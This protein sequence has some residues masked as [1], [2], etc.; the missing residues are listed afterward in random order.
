MSGEVE[1]S[2]SKIPLE[3]LWKV[4]EEVF[5]TEGL[6]AT[7]YDGDDW[8]RDSRKLRFTDTESFKSCE[9]QRRILR[10][11]CKSWKYLSDTVGRRFVPLELYDSNGKYSITDIDSIANTWRLYVGTSTKLPPGLSGATVQWRILR[12]AQDVAEDVAQISHPHLRRVEIYFSDEGDTSYAPDNL[13]G[14][15]KSFVN[16]TW[17]RYLTNTNARHGHCV[18]DDEG[19]T[20]TLPHLQVLYYYGYGALHLPYY[21]LV[22]PCL[23][24]LTIIAE[25]S[26]DSFPLRHLIAAYGESLQSLYI[27]AVSSRRGHPRREELFPDYD[28]EYFP[29]WNYVPNLRELSLGEFML[30][31]YYHLPPGHPLRAFT[32]QVCKMGDLPA[33]MDSVENLRVLRMLRTERGSDGSLIRSDIGAPI[34]SSEDLENLEA[35]AAAKG[36]VIEMF[37]NYQDTK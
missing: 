31:E 35:K 3:I 30:L 36:I 25:I 33:W 8:T 5:A 6:F 11:V 21:R 12:V 24:H 29:H 1:P 9:R 34:L 4:F 37:S 23:R 17:L 28:P 27:H 19:Q 10:S 20:I 18:K 13:V 22:L 15:L 14:V 32:A 7:T 2:S 16:I 26:V